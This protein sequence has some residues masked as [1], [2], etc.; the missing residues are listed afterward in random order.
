MIPHSWFKLENP[1]DEK[2]KLCWNL[3]NL[4]PMWKKRNQNLCVDWKIQPGRS[5][6]SKFYVLWSLVSFCWV[7]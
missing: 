3:N 6:E 1:N 2:F 5:V 4:Q 7:I